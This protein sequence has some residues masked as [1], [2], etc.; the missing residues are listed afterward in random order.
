MKS[1]SVAP[2]LVFGWGNPSRGDDAL[3]PLC[4]AQLR[5]RFAQNPRIEFLEDF[6][7]QVEH[8][9]DLLGRSQVLLVDASASG[10]TPFTSLRVQPLQDASYTSHALS[11]QALLAAFTQVSA[12][13]APPC[14][15]LA[16]RGENFELGA[17]LSPAANA[18]LHHASAWAQCWLEDHCTALG[19]AA[20][21]PT[22]A[23]AR[24]G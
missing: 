5:Q 21:L 24:A 14:T 4:V 6:Q 20:T 1:A 2:L 19:A 12:E 7:L 11:P 3:G 16:I 8:A 9:L 13:P 18:H 10:D 22:P 23:L 15:L 17:D